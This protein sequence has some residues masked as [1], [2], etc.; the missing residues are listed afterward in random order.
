[1]S[2]TKYLK[3][4]HDS[5]ITAI[6]VLKN[7]DRISGILYVMENTFDKENDAMCAMRKL[8]EMEDEI[9]NLPGNIQYPYR[10]LVDRIVNCCMENEYFEAL[11]HIIKGWKE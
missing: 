2:D 11:S 9:E 5:I 8:K 3:G 10:D 4:T 6:N 1:M 7:S